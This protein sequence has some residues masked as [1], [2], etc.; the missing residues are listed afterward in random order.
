MAGGIVF[1]ERKELWA[2]GFDGVPKIIADAGN[3]ASFRFIEFFVAHIRN[4][5]TGPSVG[6]RLFLGTHG[7]V[8]E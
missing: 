3:R 2:I 8:A 5:N 7:F 1:R 6:V 4:Q